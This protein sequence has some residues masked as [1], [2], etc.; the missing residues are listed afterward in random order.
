VVRVRGE[1]KRRLGRLREG[2]TKR[3]CSDV[4]SARGK[5]AGTTNGQAFVDI[6]VESL[7]ETD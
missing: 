5:I 6:F 1:T 7:L 2:S 4:K 3:P